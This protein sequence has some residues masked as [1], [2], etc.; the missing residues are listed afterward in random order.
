MSF[1]I[2]VQ[3]IFADLKTHIMDVKIISQN[4]VGKTF[5]FSQEGEESV[6][7]FLNKAFDEDSDAHFLV[8]SIKYIPILDVGNIQYPIK[9]DTEELRNWSFDNEANEK[10]AESFLLQII[11]NIIFNR[12]NKEINDNKIENNN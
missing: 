7:L 6:I 11:D 8:V 3:H 5:E 2:N 10:W 1:C 4:E 9:F 12:N